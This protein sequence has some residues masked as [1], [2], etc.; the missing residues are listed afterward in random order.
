MDGQGG[1]R[2]TPVRSI[3][4][5]NH[6]IAAEPTVTFDG[7]QGTNPSSPAPDKFVAT[8]GWTNV[9]GQDNFYIYSWSSLSVEYQKVGG[10]G[11]WL[12][13]T[14]NNIDIG[15][16]TYTT[17]EAGLTPGTYKLRARLPVRR[18]PKAPPGTE[19]LATYYSEERT[20]VVN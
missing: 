8:G 19:E 2:L 13:A 4:R 17:S 18:K 15:N 20:V 6:A 9:P 11:A 10:S 3:I 14:T 12:T 7:A 16:K 5:G 1:G